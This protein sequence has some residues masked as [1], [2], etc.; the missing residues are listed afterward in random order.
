MLW[1]EQQFL[2]LTWGQQGVGRLVFF[3][4]KQPVSHAGWAWAGERERTPPPGSICVVTASS[5]SQQ[6]CVSGS[7]ANGEGTAQ[8][9]C[10]R[11]DDSP[12]W[13]GPEQ[14]GEAGP[15]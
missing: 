4:W 11:K 7:P 12:G 3:V 8:G 2:R 5:S 15:L 10:G 1:V 14:E 6:G 13:V 9:R